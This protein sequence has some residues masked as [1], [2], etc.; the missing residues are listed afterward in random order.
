MIPVST[1]SQTAGHSGVWGAEGLVPHI[2]HDGPIWRLSLALG[3]S[4]LHPEKAKY[5]P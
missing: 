3:T 2:L 5:T 1:I 4:A